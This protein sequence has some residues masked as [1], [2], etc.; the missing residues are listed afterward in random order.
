MLSYSRFHIKYMYVGKCWVF[1]CC[2]KIN[3][4]IIQAL[5]V[6]WDILEGKVYKEFVF[7]E[8]SDM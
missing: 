4:S 1:K 8:E 5:Q 6:M 7:L 3:P 2:Y